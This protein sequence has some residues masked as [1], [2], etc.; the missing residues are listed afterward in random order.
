MMKPDPEENF[1][2]W[3]A[4]TVK[5]VT[6]RVERETAGMTPEQIDRYWLLKSLGRL[7]RLYDQKA[8]EF[9][10]KREL[11]HLRKRA[12]RNRAAAIPNT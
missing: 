8:P 11:S 5:E 1:E 3:V 2:L 7:L 10:I 4:A 9:L 6:A 12:L